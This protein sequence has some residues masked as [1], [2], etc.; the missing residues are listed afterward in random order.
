MSKIHH[1]YSA[2]AKSLHW[3]V[4][5]LILGQYLIGISLGYTGWKYLH[6]QVGYIIAI[7][8]LWRIIWR[9]THAYPALDSRIQGINRTLAYAGHY[10]LYLLMILVLISGFVRLAIKGDRLNILGFNFVPLLHEM[11]KAERTPF[12]LAHK[13]L[14]HGIIVIASLHVLIALA[15]QFLQQIPCLSRMLPKSLVKY[16]EEKY[17]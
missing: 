4:V 7:L 9:M 11:P 5:F 12:K 1:E 2:M 10:V 6:F 16:I 15:H 3:L 8:L 17:D 14:A 13:Y